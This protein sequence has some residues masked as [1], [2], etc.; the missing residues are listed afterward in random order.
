MAIAGAAAAI[1]TAAGVCSMPYTGAH[2]MPP[3][4]NPGHKRPRPPWVP[5]FPSLLTQIPSL[6]RFRTS[7]SIYLTMSY[8]RR[9]TDPDLP[10][11]V[12][13]TISERAAQALTRFHSSPGP[14]GDPTVSHWHHPRVPWQ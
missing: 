4:L 11:L 14:P 2:A 10:R 3:P 7:S 13:G 9:Y 12:R 8:C 6:P 5:R 1:L